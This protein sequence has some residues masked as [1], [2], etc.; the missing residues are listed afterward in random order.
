[1]FTSH[2]AYYAEFDKNILLVGWASDIF[3]CMIKSLS[4]LTLAKNTY[5]SLTIELSFMFM[6]AHDHR[7]QL[8]TQKE[9]NKLPVEAILKSTNFP[10]KS[11]KVQIGPTIFK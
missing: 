10:K 11:P 2:K 9:E 6:Y 8:H 1:M 5:N 7:K 4:Y 3:Y